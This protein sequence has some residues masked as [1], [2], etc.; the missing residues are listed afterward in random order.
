MRLYRLMLAGLLSAS[1]TA[2][3]A[4]LWVNLDRMAAGYGDFVIFYTGAEIVNDGRVAELFKV[5]TQ[6]AYQRKFDV[7]QFEWPLPFNHAPY[8]LAI[9]LPLARLSYPVAHA[10]WSAF[11]VVLLLAIAFWLSPHLEPGYRLLFTA[12]TA[13]FFPTMEALRMGQ[14]SILST[15]LLVACFAALKRGRDAAAGVLLA[16]GLYKPQ[17]VLPFAGV[18]LVQRRWKT[19]AAFGVTGAVLAAVSL[20][21]V[22]WQGALDLL[23]ILRSM[24]D[25]SYIVNPRNMPNIRG[26]LEVALPAPALSGGTLVAASSLALYGGCLFFCRGTRDAAEPGFDLRFALAIVTTTLV[27]Y[28]LYSHDLMPLV[29]ALGIVSGEAL[30]GRMTAPA[31]RFGFLALLPIFYVPLVPSLLVRDR[32]FGWGAAP[33]LLLY[34]LLVSELAARERPLPRPR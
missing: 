9:F 7:P 25:Y 10:V 18:F 23:S 5:E 2:N 4:T 33:L 6:Q 14:D 17:L 1:L 22:G 11:N 31:A 12:L 3:L 24:H 26:L 15:A 21:A 32:V 20:A 30:A 8:E 16:L 34:G 27:T 29:I 19:V 28:H 13:A